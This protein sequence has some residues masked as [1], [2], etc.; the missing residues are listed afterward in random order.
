MCVCVYVRVG[1]IFL[2]AIWG[3]KGVTA[4]DRY[5]SVLGLGL[6]TFLLGCFVFL[7]HNTDSSERSLADYFYEALLP[8]FGIA[9]MI[10]FLVRERERERERERGR[11]RESV[12]V[13][14][15]VCACIYLC[16]CVYV[17]VWVCVTG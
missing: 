3:K 12:C 5:A 1:P 13:C 8:L 9:L 6:M 15:C 11:E 14:V 2:A 16:M 7:T 10:V 4:Q 17:T